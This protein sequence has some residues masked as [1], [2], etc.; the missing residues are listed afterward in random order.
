M[1]FHAARS[2]AG[3]DAGTEAAGRRDARR[4]ED[5]DFARHSAAGTRP[6]GASAES[7]PSSSACGFATG[8]TTGTVLRLLGGI[9]AG[10]EMS[11][12][13]SGSDVARQTSRLSAS[14]CLSGISLA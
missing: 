9:C 1:S 13:L 3:T 12:G 6:I 8:S 10:S 7:L 2:A 14:R 4:E 5:L 11:V